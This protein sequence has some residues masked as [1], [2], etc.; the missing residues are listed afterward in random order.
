MN[1]RKYTNSVQ[2]LIRNLES[3]FSNQASASASYSK[4]ALI[5]RID[6]VI[7]KQRGDWI[8]SQQA[9]TPLEELEL[10]D[11]L[12]LYLQEQKHE[13]VRYRIFEALFSMARETALEY[14]RDI[15]S[16]LVSLAIVSKS[17]ATLECAALWMKSTEKSHV[18]HLVLSLVTDYC[19]LQQNGASDLKACIDFSP[20]FC[21]IFL[22]A[23]TSHYT[24]MSSEKCKEG[25]IIVDDLKDWPCLRLLDIVQHWLLKDPAICYC[26]ATQMDKLW[27]TVIKATHSLPDSLS[28]TPLDGLASWC[29]KTPFAPMSLLAPV[30]TTDECAEN[31]TYS[32]LHSRMHYGFLKVLLA[33][34]PALKAIAKGSVLGN[35]DLQLWS[36]QQAHALVGDLMSLCNH[37]DAIPL[38][39]SADELAVDRFSQISQI[40]M[41]MRVLNCTKDQFQSL[42][43]PLPKTRLLEI[44]AYGPNRRSSI[45]E[46]PMEISTNY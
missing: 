14:R 16:K 23:L 8:S 45:D 21:C 28:L 17:S 42:S 35:P 24:M 3:V 27:R 9:L 43:D 38:S 7:F 29:V 26:T 12:G 19:V 41:S 13:Y 31:L 25:G 15:L 46:T 20:R 34:K 6:D 18:V 44:V 22:I 5:S 32:E 10:I 33:S 40:A 11:E 36:K 4:E 1:Q 2:E 30:I 39:G 37:S